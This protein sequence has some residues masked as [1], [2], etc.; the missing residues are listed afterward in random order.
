[1]STVFNLGSIKNLTVPSKW[2][3]APMEKG[4][5]G[6]ISNVYKLNEDPEVEFLLYYR[7]KEV[8]LD[9]AS[10]FKAVLASPPHVLSAAEYATIEVVLRHMSED[11]FFE[12]YRVVTTKIGGQTVL[13]TEGRWIVS[14]VKNLALFA[15]GNNSGSIIDELHYYAPAAK[16]DKYMDQGMAIFESIKFDGGD[17]STL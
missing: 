1:L 13:L 15:A 9:I 6:E 4:P 7:G 16:Y 12:R 8:A 2:T 10:D 11:D 3:A 17:R 14:D 5:K